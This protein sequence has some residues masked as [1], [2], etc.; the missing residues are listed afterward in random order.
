MLML[1]LSAAGIRKKM[2]VNYFDSVRLRYKFLFLL[3][4]NITD[5]SIFDNFM[6]M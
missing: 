4:Y 6:L 1:E 2:S 3:F 5:F